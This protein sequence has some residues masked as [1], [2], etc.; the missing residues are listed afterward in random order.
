MSNGD[1]DGDGTEL[2]WWI[3]AFFYAMGLGLNG[4]EVR[5]NEHGKVLLD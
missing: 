1:G 5:W 3:C 2:A 4:Y